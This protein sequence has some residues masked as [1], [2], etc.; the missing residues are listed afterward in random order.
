MVSPYLTR[1]L[2]TVEQVAREHEEAQR[3][4][5]TQTAG[6]AVL[7]PAPMDADAA[8]RKSHRGD[9]GDGTRRGPRAFI[10]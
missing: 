5:L 6:H 8:R 4:R 1:P 2:R 3:R 9:A 10:G 7:E